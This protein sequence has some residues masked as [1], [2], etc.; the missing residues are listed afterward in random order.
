MHII[1][2]YNSVSISQLPSIESPRSEHG[3]FR[4]EATGQIYQGLTIASDMKGPLT[5]GTYPLDSIAEEMRGYGDVFYDEEAESPMESEGEG[6]ASGEER[7]RTDSQGSITSD[8]QKQGE[9]HVYVDVYAG[10]F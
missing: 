3:G 4:Y 9:L 1:I 10:F 2:R 8:E 6:G 7:Q 5:G